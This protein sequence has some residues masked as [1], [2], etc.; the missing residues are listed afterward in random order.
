MTTLWLWRLDLPETTL[1]WDWVSVAEVRTGETL[2][3]AVPIDSMLSSLNMLSN[4]SNTKH[5]IGVSLEALVREKTSLEVPLMYWNSPDIR[6][7]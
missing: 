6:K 1:L 2:S 3:N 4:N 7:A 5:A